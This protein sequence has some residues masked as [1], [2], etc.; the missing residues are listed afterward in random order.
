MNEQ[1]NLKEI[2]KFR[3]EKLNNIIKSGH[4]PYAYNFHKTHNITDLIKK[5]KSELGDNV[6]IA[7]RM[8]SFRKMGKASFTHIQD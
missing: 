3:Y 7:G 8:I 4:N 1:K 2:I 6:S 5:G